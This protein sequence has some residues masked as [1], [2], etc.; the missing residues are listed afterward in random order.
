MN[1]NQRSIV[2]FY[3][4]RWLP[5]AQIDDPRV[6]K[7]LESLEVGHVEPAHLLGGLARPGRRLVIE[8]LDH[9]LQVP[10]LGQRVNE[11][12]EA[13]RSLIG[14]LDEVGQQKEEG[15]NQGY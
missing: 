7:D 8:Q 11:L 6:L 2:S 9:F 4:L 10:A 13:L 1:I 5:V 12:V 14:L 15:D 3:G